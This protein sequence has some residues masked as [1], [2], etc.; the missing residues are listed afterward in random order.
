MEDSIIWQVVWVTLTV[1]IFVSAL[2]AGR[3]RMAMYVGR[4]A[5]AAL[6]IGAG[7]LFNALNLAT[8]ASY[9]G[10]ADSSYIPFVRDTWRSVV[11]AHQFIFIPLLVAFEASVGILVLS[12]GRR[13]QLGL[14]GVMGFVIALLSFGWAYYAFSIPMLVAFVLLLRAER[15]HAVT[16][17]TVGTQHEERLAA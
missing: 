3:S 8:G 5:I 13:T 10:F 2:L 14:V 12:G 17:S 11:G 6:W 15:E 9:K 4:A 16:P 1:T 7:A